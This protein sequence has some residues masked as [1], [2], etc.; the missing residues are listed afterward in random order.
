MNQPLLAAYIVSK[1]GGRFMERWLISLKTSTP[2]DGYELAI[3]LSQKGIQY[4]QPSAELRRELRPCYAYDV[5]SL[6][7]VSQVIAINFQ[8]IAAANNYWR[9]TC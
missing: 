8:T 3:L 2:Q 1:E 6:I 9:D 4:T 5:D 7:A